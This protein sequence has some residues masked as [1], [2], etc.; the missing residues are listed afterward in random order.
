M[1]ASKDKGRF[2][3]AAPPSDGGG[4]A[5]PAAKDA[6]PRARSKKA[7]RI[8]GA[9][10]A[11]SHSTASGK[12]PAFSA[13]T[14]DSARAREPR[15]TSAH[16]EAGGT[17]PGAA[18]RSGSSP[19]SSPET[20]PETSPVPAPALETA[21]PEP[22]A[23]HPQGAPGTAAP[24]QDADEDRAIKSKDVLEKPEDVLEKPK[25]WQIAPSAIDFEDPLLS[26]LATLAGLLE[27]PISAEALKAGL[28][29]AE[30]QFTPEL[31]VRAAERA[32]IEARITR[33]PQLRRIL[34]VTLPC[35]LLL[36]GGNACVLLSFVDRA[37]AEIVVPEGGAAKKTVDLEELQSQ[38]TGYALF[39]RPEFKFDER[40]S[41]IRLTQS[42]AWF[43]GTLAK[44]WPIYTHV[45]LASALINF[46]ALASPLFIMNVYDRVVPNNAIETLW[47]LALGVV[48]VF[49]FE[50]VMR[51][52]RAY[53]VDV[54]G[55][56]ADVIIASRL[57]EQL[58]SMKLAAKGAS[59]GAM[60]NNLREFES[61]R[62][63][64]TSST[65]V[66]LVD[67]PFIFLFIAVIWLVAGPVA[68]IPL[69][70]VPVVVLVGV[71]MQFP[72]RK[73]IEK[74]HREST[75]KHALLVETI[76]GLE[77][78]KAAA[79]EGRVQRTW[80]RFVGL[81]AESSGKA[82]FIS[83]IATTFAQVSI[84]MTTV[85]VVVYGV[86]LIADGELTMGA[87]IAATILTG[88]S[89]APLSSIAAML[90]RLQ[91]SRVA[92]KSLDAIM[93]APVERS[94]DKSFL[95]RPSLN[96]RIEFQ[97]V[98]FSYP[99]QE[100]QALDAVSFKIEPGERVGFLGRIGSGKSTIAR[101][102][103][104]LYEPADGAVLMD[105]T[106]I[107]QIDPADLRRNVG[108]VSQDNYLFFGT[109]RDNIAFGAPHLDDQSVMRAAHVAGV[110]DFLRAHPHGFDLQ[111]GERGMSL[112][113]GQRQA[114]VIARALLL[115]PPMILL[116]E[117]TSN[118]DNSTEMVFKKR[119][120]EILPDKTLLL[121]THRS[122]LL[123][124]IDRLIIV[125]AGKIVADGPKEEVLSALKQGQIRTANG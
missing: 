40:A 103:I 1:T 32:G 17:K 60:A 54:A 101:L 57:L 45:I 74:T 56:N 77:T 12:R 118:M 28:P 39:A 4:G 26:C 116:D 107:R 58:M 109:V 19:G 89:L 73:V 70:V 52:L 7:A 33:R 20:S 24:A 15:L 88:R 99:N 111:V 47:V 14:D 93:T 124:L 82:R 92:L 80:E 55:K 123:T 34:P 90:T 98:S 66:V 96:G 105:G 6:A 2:A 86:Y 108:Y 65:V 81:T 85:A 37:Q 13:R 18:A 62:E 68:F 25:E 48:T 83:G 46:F 9:F 41:E 29:H 11:A 67:L 117:P 94:A 91:Q 10:A 100:I 119:L 49:A 87:L 97:Q 59:T 23:R 113:G 31:A 106:D 112:S 121:V 114:I 72:L 115:D 95:H 120:S 63:F 35:I 22:G 69:A 125:D 79:A 21:A 53:F 38:Y 42:R 50:F 64:F 43:W 8:I 75:Q 36:E 44:F 110:S 27:R 71:I 30:E 3:A 76:D 122:S 102:L 78:I 51:N 84:Q 5:K 104:G 16:G 61:L